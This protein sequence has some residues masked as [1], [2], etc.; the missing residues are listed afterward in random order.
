MGKFHVCHRIVIRDED[1]RIVSDE[2]Y[3]NFI[4]GKD[5]FDRVEAMPGQTVALQHGARVILKKFR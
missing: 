4:E 2:P 3:D 5:A 1:D